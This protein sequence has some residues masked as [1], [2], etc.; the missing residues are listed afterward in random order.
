MKTITKTLPALAAAFLFAGST[1]MAN[2]NGVGLGHLRRE[3][4]GAFRG[5]RCMSLVD[6]RRDAFNQRAQLVAAQQARLARQAQLARELAAVRAREAQLQ[7]QLQRTSGYGR[8]CGATCGTVVAGGYANGY[9]NGY[10]TTSYATTGYAGTADL[11][12]S[13]GYWINRSNAVTTNG[14]TYVSAN[15]NV[16]TPQTSSGTSTGYRSQAAFLDR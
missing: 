10:A 1:L 12:T 2:G 5:P 6:A 15:R 11:G 13:G 3:G 16:V 9:V 4:A 8:G 14:T 7:A